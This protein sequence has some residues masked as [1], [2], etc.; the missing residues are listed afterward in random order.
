ML[1][2]LFIAAF[3]L[4]SIAATGVPAVVEIKSG[5]LAG[6]AVWT[7]DLT[8]KK[9]ALT[10]PLQIKLTV[11]PAHDIVVQLQAPSSQIS[12][13]ACTFKFTPANWNVVQKGNI[14]VNPVF[15]KAQIAPLTAAKNQLSFPITIKTN[16]NNPCADALQTIIKNVVVKFPLKTSNVCK[17]EGD[18]HITTLG[19][20]IYDI[21]TEGTFT[22]LRTPFMHIEAEQVKCGATVTCNRGVAFRYLD[23]VFV[24]RATPG[25]SIVE[26]TRNVGFPLKNAEHAI[27]A[28][29]RMEEITVC[30]L[31]LTRA[32]DI[33]D[34]NC[35]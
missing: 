7:F 30:F 33:V 29:Q 16:L 15:T 25:M 24:A 26:S 19:S 22:L 20:A 14:I 10:R 11:K 5:T 27:T 17:S 13:S 3:L 18:P 8:A 32:D 28:V 12:F 6:D 1:K 31:V 34:G 21:Q 23:K 2:L 9:E 35:A 4:P